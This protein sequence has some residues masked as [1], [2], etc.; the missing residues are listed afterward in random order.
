MRLK[1]LENQMRVFMNPHDYQTM[2]DCADSRRARLAMRIMGEASLRVDELT[3]IERGDVRES[4]DPDVDL[5]F[6]PL[7][8]KDTKARDTDGKRRDA[9]IPDDL[10]QA[11]DEYADI[12]GRS[13][14]DSYFMCA[15]R[16]LQKDIER[17]REHAVA[18]TGEGDY[19][20]V[21]CHDFRAYFATNLALREGVN[22]DIVMELGGWDDEETFRGAYLNAQFDDIIQMH[23]A[24]AGVIEVEDDIALTEYQ[25]LQQEIEALREAVEDLDLN[26]NINGGGEADSSE[27]TLDDFS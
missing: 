27:S 10:K 15:K 21:S 7:Y 26:I 8:G 23:L 20:H 11:M 2:L 14:G 9:W 18:K 6:L 12:N 13:D 5:Y 19:Q 3:G 25:K 16:T 22:D 1:T 17:T 24:Q 4:T